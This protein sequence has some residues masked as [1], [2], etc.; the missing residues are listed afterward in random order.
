MSIR[1]VEEPEIVLTR[2]EHDR[3]HQQYE[4]THRYWSATVPP[5]TFEEWLRMSR[6][7]NRTIEVR[8]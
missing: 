1:I 7:L 2:S 4:M 6:Q 8:L 3:L 5:P